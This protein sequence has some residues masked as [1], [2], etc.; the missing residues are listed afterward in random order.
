[1]KAEYKPY[2]EELIELAIKEDN[3]TVQQYSDNLE[4]PT[5]N[6][7]EIYEI[8]QKLL[9]QKHI[10]KRNIRALT[11]RTYNLVKEENYQQLH[12]DFD[13]DTH[14]KVCVVDNT[15]NGIRKK[16]GNDKIFNGCRLYGTK[17]PTGKSEHSSLP[18]ASF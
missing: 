9:F 10:W 1:M 7:K 16:L 14:E 17:M 11:V 8:A 4:F 5:H 2:V 18:P 3:L 12:I 6:A 13:I 15:L